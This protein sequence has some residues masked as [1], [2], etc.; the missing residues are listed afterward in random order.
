MPNLLHELLR[1][2]AETR[3]DLDAVRCAARSLSYAELDH[4]SDG[5]A[6]ALATTGVAPR[7]R[8]GIYLPKRVE[9][10]VALYGV[11][12]TG[13]TYVPLDPRAPVRRLG[14]V[15]AD[16][17]VA[18]VV[19]TSSMA[20]GLLG[21]MQEHL[22]RVVVLV[23]DGTE[24]PA[25]PCRVIRFEEAAASGEGPFDPGVI[26]DDLAYILYTSGS[27]GVPKGVMLTHRN[28]VSFVRWCF[29]QIG[30]EPED[31]LS[32]HAP[33]HFD[34]SVF[35][36]YLAAMAAVPVVMVPEDQAY[37]GRA[38]LE[39]IEAEGITV[40]YSVPSALTLMARA[41]R[42]PEDLAGLR[43]VV[44]AGEVFST[45]HR[46]EFQALLSPDT[47]L[48]NLY[49]PTET[50]VCTYYQVR[51][52]PPDDRT[53]PIGRACENDEVFALKEDGSVAGV[54][55]E[56][57]LF[58]RGPTVMKGYWG[59]PE[60]TAEMLVPDPR[61]T[62]YGDPVYRTGDLVR[63]RPDG[64]YDFLGRRDH[65]IKSRGYRIELGEI[66][67]AL[68]SHPAVVE[69]VAVAISHD[70][71]GTAIVACV[72][73]RDGEANGVS[74]TAIKRHLAER[75]PRYMIPARIDVMEKLPRTSNGKIDRQ[76]LQR[77]ASSQPIGA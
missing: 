52:L 18:A 20:A 47:T 33:L 14:L 43:R 34:L 6:A 68:N 24:P 75:V 8:V 70:E 7:D 13:A 38:L 32:N 76:R 60:Q 23:D 69:A 72:V 62:T 61:S 10:L 64:D 35:D 11:M 54:G 28:A 15:A 5:L 59:R 51:D 74:P 65:Q 2:A 73:V 63:L 41:A 71:W 25:L 36:L 55:E 19:T 26:E 3:P 77:E 31:V 9:G 66:E 29:D 50:N 30:V 37:F 1:S 27:T 56:G 58:V 16:C 4:Q 57:E 42:G 46:R 21:A 40:W 49:G 22:P 44:F 39:L 17:R 45:R 48:W 53:I 12:K 67:A